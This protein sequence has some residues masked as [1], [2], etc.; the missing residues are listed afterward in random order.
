MFFRTWNVLYVKTG[1]FCSKCAGPNMAVFFCNS[2]ISCFPR[3]LLRY[4]LDVFEIVTVAPIITRIT[5]AF[6]CHV[7]RVSFQG[8]HII[9]SFQ[10]LS[11]NTFLSPKAAKF[12]N[13]H[14]PSFVI[15]DYKV[16]FFVRDGSASLHCL[17]PSYGCLTFMIGFD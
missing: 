2:L 16:Q 12:V 9:E 6:T 4:C 14:V 1:T 15:T 5:F 10:L 11:F 7:R 13:V 17:I 3:M 8:L